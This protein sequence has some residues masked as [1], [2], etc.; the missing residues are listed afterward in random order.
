MRPQ[1]VVDY[2]P[3]TFY[4][5]LSLAFLITFLV[6]LW[7]V[8]YSPVNADE[9][10]W[11]LMIAR[12]ESDHGKL[13]YLFAQCREG[14]WIDA[15]LT[16]YPAMA[17]NS[18]L[19]EDASHPW[20]LRLHGWLLF[21]ALLGMW[22]WLLN[23]RAGLGW[24]DSFLAVSAFLSVGVLPFL[25]VYERPEQPLLLLVTLALAV[26]LFKAPQ[27]R[28]NWGVGLLVVLGFALVATLMSA[29]HP[30][31][32]FLFPVLLVLAWRQLQSLTLMVVLTAIMGWTAYDTLQVWQ[33]RTTCPEFPG[34]MKV[35]Q[36]LTLRPGLLI[37]DPFYFLRTSWN[38]FLQFGAYV[39][40]LD[41]R[42]SYVSSWL[43]ES[44]G[45]MVSEELISIANALLWVPLAVA[46][47]VITANWF[48]DRRPR[49]W[50]EGLLWFSL[51]LA[52]SSIVVLQTQ[53]NFYEAAIIWPLVLLLVV[54]SF[55]QP[56]R[57][58]GRGS[59]RVVIAVLMSV[60]LLSGVLRIER[61]G[62]IVQ[63]WRDARTQ[64][65]ET[66]DRQNQALREFARAQ[67]GIQ[68]NAPR[69]V[70][71]KNTYQAFW[72]HE[73][74]IFLDY[75]A[76]WWAAESDVEQTFR[77]RRV[78]GLVAR[79]VNVPEAIRARAVEFDGYCC[80]SADSLR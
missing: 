35:L 51:L 80:I 18:W 40:S 31:G 44:G 37:S 42:D 46:L 75:A 22:T 30:K 27:A 4:A 62:E 8:F 19:Y 24:S 45:A 56:F 48:S 7:I 16:W 23:R 67:C 15:P 13:V 25:M 77:Q 78:Q 9:I 5:L 55:G 43:P 17:I 68:D 21:L 47:L 60:A 54:F 39:S 63:V 41:F 74:P 52:L 76:G 70:L 1:S 36:G 28:V 58:P 66:V 53:K 72:D 32:M 73:Q 20:D 65:A 61:F 64:Q 6:T 79:C 71:D 10:F 69:L 29:L 26:T 33:L 38:N 12:L 2:F 3:R 50:T 49:G 34:L 11:K 59:V 14:Q 57:Q